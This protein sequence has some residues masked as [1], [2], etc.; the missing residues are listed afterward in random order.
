[1]NQQ[2]DNKLVSEELAAFEKEKLSRRSALGRLGFLAGAAAVTALTSDELLRKVG[3]RLSQFSGDSDVAR[4]V[5]REFQAAGVALASP[6]DP[7]S[8]CFSG[9]TNTVGFQCQPCSM[10]CGS[11]TAKHIPK[12]CS[13]NSSSCNECCAEQ[14]A[15]CDF[16]CNQYLGNQTKYDQCRF[17]CGVANSECTRSCP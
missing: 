6:S 17:L 16:A 1:M 4:Q 2:N 15:V 11:N 8:G 13:S 3:E 12:N 9:C 14:K 10:S 5:A 7:C